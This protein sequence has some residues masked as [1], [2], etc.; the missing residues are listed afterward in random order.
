MRWRRRRDREEDL[1]RELNSDLEL[2]A[3]EQEENGLPQEEAQY[4][5]KRALGNVM[6]IKEEIRES[7]SWSSLDGVRQD[8]VYAVRSF[9]R[10]REFTVVVILTLALGIGATTSMFSIVEAVLLNPLPFRNPD[11]LVAIFEKLVQKPDDPAFFDTYHDFQNWKS[12]N[13]SF[14]QLSVAT[15]AMGGLSQILTGAGP[16]REV[17]AM[18]VGI[19]FFPLLGVAPE[20]GRTFQPE[21]LNSGCNVVL[22]HS[23]WIETFGGER[24]V[25]GRLI[26]INDESCTVI[27]VMPQVFT[28]YP[29]ATNMWKLIV[30]GSRI[31][32]NP[33]A[34]VG[35]FGLLKPGVS[36][37]HAEEELKALYKNSP[38]TDVSTEFQPAVF[39]LAE[40]FA[41]L[42]GPTLRLTV[43]LL[44]GAVSFVLLIGCLNIANLL[45]GESVARQKELGVRAALGA[46][47]GRIIRQLLTE[48]LLLAATGAG[49][50]TVLALTAVH[51]FRTLH[52]IE[53]PPGNPVS[54]NIPVLV[55]TASLTVVTALGF[56]LVP[57]IKASR[58]ELM[59]GLRVSAQAA[60]LSRAARTLRRALVVAEVALS[61]ALLVAAGLLIQSSER[62]AAVSLG[63]RTDHVVTMPVV[64]PSW[65]YTSNDQRTRFFHAALERPVFE[66]G[67]VRAAFASLV[68]PDGSGGDAVAVDGKPEP[69]SRAIGDVLQISVSPEYFGVMG[70]PLELG[71]VFVDADGEKSAAVA[72]VNKAFNRTYFPGESPVGRRIKVF[73][74]QESERPWLTVVGVVGNEKHQNFFRPMSWE[75][76]PIVFRPV[77]QS[78][79][80]RAYLV[81][82]TPMD[83]AS[84]TSTLRKQIGELDNNVPIGDVRLMDERVSQTL[85]YPK[86]RATILSAFAGF[87]L[88]LAAI[89]LYAVLS[90]LAAQRT[91]EFGVRMA[92][93]AQ[94]TDL[95]RLVLW[96]GMTLTLAGL[97]SGLV[98]ALSLGGVLR[99]LVYGLTT[100]DAMTLIA[101]SILLALLALLATYVPALRASRIDP[102]VALRYE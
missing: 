72:V 14:E 7:W 65:I 38:R 59:D 66:S 33:N 70:V 41:L 77:D 50:G 69:D 53:M 10:A 8:L 97:A 18:P 1:E 39:P 68:P 88:L 20:L 24:N 35:V 15:W 28:F 43:G 42:T 84:I 95:L 62:L 40:Q 78:P 36:I 67:M 34:A 46:G 96:E 100:T 13:Q 60:S 90:H 6:A 4:A 79:P 32:R 54:V 57:A 98:L 19:D 94:K 9:R 47:R 56:G 63:F 27:G 92:L 49:L 102:K 3:L 11:R 21:D 48:S 73:A 58:G 25:L 55:F 51:Y 76:T 2:E 99:T 37:S 81:F 85:L 12:G 91:Q 22:K 23:F 71:R 86:L 5:A 101:A 75:E 87:A 52:P 16:T 82:R 45:L 29:D 26:K 61:L 80:S 31:A 30:P 17:L 83:T 74:G 64:L 89:G 93:G 44:F